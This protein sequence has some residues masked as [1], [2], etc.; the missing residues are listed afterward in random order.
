MYPALAREG[1]A[2]LDAIVTV[3]DAL[4]MRDEFRRKRLDGKEFGRRW[5]GKFG[6]SAGGIL[7]YRVA[8]QGFGVAPEL[9]K[10][11]EIIR[12]L[13]PQAEDSG[14]QLCWCR[15]WEDSEHA[16]FRLRQGGYFCQMDRSHRRAQRKKMVKKAAKHSN[17]IDTFVYNRRPAFIMGLFDDCC[18]QMVKNIIRYKGM[19]Y[20]NDEYDALLCVWAGRQ[21]DRSTQCRTIVCRHAED[22]A[23]GSLWLRRTPE[24]FRIGTSI[25]ATVCR[26]SSLSVRIWTR[27]R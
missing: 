24:Y 11:K 25:M 22:E 10:L 17:G 27:R 6:D 9:G 3:V 14:M 18:P 12:V 7:Q 19:C 2:R 26:S 15:P 20:F 21:T 1:I 5:F 8:Q 16:S 4:R 23:S 13:Q